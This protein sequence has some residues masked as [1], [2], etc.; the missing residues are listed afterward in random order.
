MEMVYVAIS[1]TTPSERKALNATVLSILMSETRTVNK[2]V[3]IV[4]L[5]GTWKRDETCIGVRMRSIP[6]DDLHSAADRHDERS[7]EDTYL[8][9]PFREREVAASRKCKCLSGR[10]CKST[11]K[12]H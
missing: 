9:H 11:R 7:K 4:E 2:H 3:T 6:R 5:T 10:C 1:P 12:D 8:A